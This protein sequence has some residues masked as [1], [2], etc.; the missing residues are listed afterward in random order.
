MQCVS[1]YGLNDNVR[2]VGNVSKS[3]ERL[4]VYTLFNKQKRTFRKRRLQRKKIK[5]NV[6]TVEEQLKSR[7]NKYKSVDLTLSIRAYVLNLLRSKL[8]II[9]EVT[10]N[11]VL[12]E[13][14]S[15]R[16]SLLVKDMVGYRLR[17]KVMQNKTNLDRES[18]DRQ[19]MNVPFHDKGMD[20][21]DL[22]RILN[23][24]K[25]GAAIPNYLKGLPPIV[26]YMYTRT[27]GGKIFNNGQKVEELD[28]ENGTEGMQCN[29]SSS[30]YKYDL[31][32]HVLT[33]DLSIIRDV[34][35]D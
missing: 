1:P 19:L 31:C 2:G 17:W 35:F 14:I 7:L 32:G 8:G 24:K 27:I 11:L 9:V 33:G 6:N 3:D 18:C 25:V 20:M 28:V 16:T 5:V 23:S 26:S 21:V 10:E 34:K 29:C 15:A 22:P 12:H 13:E 30:E 4:I